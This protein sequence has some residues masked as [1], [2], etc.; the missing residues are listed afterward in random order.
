MDEQLSTF[1][2]STE[3]T[4]AGINQATR[5]KGMQYP[6]I[7]VTSFTEVE[8]AYLA[9]RNY[10]HSNKLQETSF[11]LYLKLEKGYKLLGYIELTWSTLIH[12]CYMC[13]H[14]IYIKTDKEHTSELT[15]TLLDSL[16][17][18]Q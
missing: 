17:L 10:V 7:Y 1:L 5:S 18:S 8:L 4:I 11:P 2:H 12:I 15:G 6:F 16:L 13:F 9:D 3:D 14:E